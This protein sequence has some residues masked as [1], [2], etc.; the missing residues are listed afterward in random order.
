VRPGDQAVGGAPWERRRGAGFTLVELLV[1]IV[2]VIIVISLLVPCFAR[3]S[4]Q[5][6]VE[7]C[8]S[9]LKEMHRA[10]SVCYEGKPVPP[11]E[12]VP[13]GSAF[14]TQFARMAPP[15]LANEALR[16][17]L[18]EVPAAPDCDYRGPGGFFAKLGERE[19]LG[20][21]HNQ[22]HSPDGREGGNVLLRSGEVITEDNSQEGGL[23]GIALQNCRP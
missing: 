19:P 23:W 14:W 6:K 7:A 21:D 11:P 16:C 8:R 5:E 3:A 9:R 2:G 15:L 20:C 1:A 10:M 12:K 4:R 18:A 17:P 13:Q 22:N